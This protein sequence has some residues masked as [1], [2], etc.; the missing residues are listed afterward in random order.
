M[1]ARTRVR[2]DAAGLFVRT[3]GDVFRPGDIGGYAHAYDM[4]D[5]GLAEGDEVRVSAISGTPLCRVTRDGM[6]LL[7]WGNDYLHEQEARRSRERGDGTGLGLP[8]GT[9]TR[10]RRAG[11]PEDPQGGPGGP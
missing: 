11:D 10:L 4:S 6:P 5:G 3:N 8:E 9:V 1:S 7:R 2:K